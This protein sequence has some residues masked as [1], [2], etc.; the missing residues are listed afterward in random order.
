M[1]SA[2]PTKGCDPILASS[3]AILSGG[4]TKSTQPLAT[5]LRGMVS[6]FADFSSWAKVIPPS[7][8]MA[9]SPSVPSVAVPERITPIALLCRVSASDCRKKSI[10]MC[11]SAVRGTRRSTPSE[12]TIFLSGGIT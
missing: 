5:A 6:Y 12:M 3:S 7:A 4:S 9:F 8:L 2:G 1:A 11:P 10:G